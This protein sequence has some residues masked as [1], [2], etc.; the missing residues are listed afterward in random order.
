MPER[1]N[2]LT[3]LSDTFTV[4]TFAY[5]DTSNSLRSGQEV[6]IELFQPIGEITLEE[7]MDQYALPDPGVHRVFSFVAV[8]GE[9]IIGDESVKL[10][11]AR[12]DSVTTYIAS[13]IIP[14]S[15]RRIMEREFNCIEGSSTLL[16]DSYTT[17][18]KRSGLE[19]LAISRT[20]SIFPFYPDQDA[21][22][23]CQWMD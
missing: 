15:S 13:R 23:K 7:W 16:R 8:S 11:S 6:P 19:R 12:R 20:R 3:I 4:C 21:H 22:Y 2:D 1:L 17:L 9:V 5:A 18:A 10:F 14:T